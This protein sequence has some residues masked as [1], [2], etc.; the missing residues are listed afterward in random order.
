M[1]ILHV[2]KFAHPQIRILPMAWVDW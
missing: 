1:R 2:L